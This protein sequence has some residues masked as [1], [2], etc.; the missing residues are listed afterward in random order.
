MD[1]DPMA[2]LN[3][4]AGGNRRHISHMRF[5]PSNDSLDAQL[6]QRLQ[7][8]RQSIAMSQPNNQRVAFS[9]T[10]RLVYGLGFAWLL[11]VATM[12]SIFAVPPR[13]NQVTV[14]EKQGRVE[15]A[16]AGTNVW[17][18]AETNQ[19]LHIADR[20]RTGE[21]SRATL[22]LLDQSTLRMAELTEFQVEPI[23]ALPGK[24]AFSLGKGLLYFF[25]RDKPA[26]VQF[27]TR[28]ATAAIRGTEF[29]LAVAENGRTELT[30]F[31]GEVQLSND[32]GSIQLKNGEQG[33]V[34]PGQPP[35]KSP[36]INAINIIQWC[37][38]YPGVLDVDEL[39]LDASAQSVL[40][41]SLDAYRAGDLLT[42]LAVYPEGRQATSE[43]EKTYRAALLLAV[44]K[45]DETELLLTSQDNNLAAAL[46]QLIAAVKNTSTTN[47]VASSTNS[48]TAALVQS[49]QFQAQS[50]LPEALLAA[51]HAVALSPNFG[52][53]WTRVAELEFSFGRTKAAQAALDKALLLSPRNAQA[54]ALR[55]FTLAAQNRIRE[56]TVEFDRAI[57]LDGAL[58]NAWLGRGLC[59]FRHG[60]IS[61][62][63]DDLQVAATLEP[64]RALLRSYLAKAWTE[65]GDSK[66]A[67][68][69]LALA[70]ERDA[71][72]PTAWLYSALLLQQQNRINEGIE[73]LERS[74]ALNDN[75]RV[76]RSRLMLDQDRAVRGANLANI[77]RDA[78]M[79]D[80]SVREAAKAVNA[81]YAN[82]SA[83]LFLAN[84]YHELRDPQ[85]V[86]LRYETPFVSEF[87]VAHLLAPVGA[88]NLSQQ[89]SQQEYSKLFERDG[90]GVSS[91]TEYFSEGSWRIGAAQFGAFVGTSFAVEEYYESRDGTRPNNDLEF[92]EYDIRLK[93]QITPSDTI[94]F[95]ATIA[96]SSG[97]NLA[98]YYSQSDAALA[99]F[100][101]DDR[102]EPILIAG[103]H[104]EWSPGSHTLLLASRLSDVYSVTNPLAPTYLV[105]RPTLTSPISVVRPIAM[106][107]EYRSKMEIYTAEAQHIW[108][109][110]DFTTIAGARYQHGDF[111]T[112]NAQ[113]NFDLALSGVFL[114]PV[115]QDASVD[116]RRTSI[117]GYE[118]WRVN[119]LLSLIGGLSYEWLV[120][121]EDFRF[122][123]LS[124]E[125]DTSRHLLPKAGFIWTPF[126][127]TA[128]RAGYSKSVGGASFDQSF[129]LEP[130]QVAGF[131]QAFRSL[132]PESLVGANAGAEFTAYGLSLE[133]KISTRTY[134][135]IEGGVLESSVDR[136]IGAF[137]LT[138]LGGP[139]VGS[140]A[141]RLDFQEKFV[142]LSLHQLVGKQWS[143]GAGYR[144]SHAEL[145]DNYLDVSDG[146]GAAFGFIPRKT[147]S[148]TL[149][150]LDIR[151]IWQHP[152]GLFAQVN[153][154]WTQQRTG[155][156]LSVLDGDDF[157]QWNILAGYRFSQRRAAITVGVLNLTDRDYQL[158]PINLYRETPRDRTFYAQFTFQF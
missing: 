48:A 74:Q 87:L 57:A 133:Q 80:V 145:K 51:K 99:P 84:S 147:Y 76:Y 136:Q 65:R 53:G 92:R 14:L 121:P 110:P 127:S 16:S 135:A 117:Y 11:S 64:N 132:I 42:A 131:N 148:G 124:Q 86:N 18:A 17:T 154:E 139:F 137:V 46:R 63:R 23:E 37:L 45:V 8:H 20:L 62:G 81:D 153:G 73:V 9:S 107:Q 88:G 118:Q 67:E 31:D 28:T 100:R 6:T 93:Q 3:F 61:E 56:A 75:R 103:Y 98:Q 72:D 114:A 108:Q 77:Y 146:A 50:R 39:R 90:L 10:R 106:N 91:S 47:V 142:S 89:V 35:V 149:Q 129:Q 41:N 12:S 150:M 60:N 158:S 112:R 40:K 32:L 49:Y 156:V 58:A 144:L 7:P 21:R 25:H 96:N 123:P 13:E 34:E 113:V 54:V 29:H 52:F 44:G 27:K 59:R 66:H 141:E 157:W 4:L 140:L 82:Y 143:F 105:A 94:F 33:V 79:T 43:S 109:T 104:H 71:N 85:G 101:F 138:S 120:L 30:M 151:A 125:T 83:H 69:E 19:V 36:T 119:D 15:A 134:L 68:Q 126:E 111:N 38:Y 130:T 5:P 26:D 2:V 22:H 116:F 155:G 97:G 70:K 95:Q 24:P 55:G 115:M 152:A 1:S 78:G 128:I 122:A 102:Q